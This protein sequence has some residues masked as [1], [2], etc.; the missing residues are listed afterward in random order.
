MTDKTRKSFQEY[1]VTVVRQDEAHAQAHSH[2]F[3]LPLGVRRGDPSAGFN[4]AETLLAALGACLITN[5]TSLAAKMRLRV[6]GVR[7]EVEGLRQDDPPGIVQIRYRLIL[8]SPEPPE[9]LERLHQLAVEW[10]TV[11][12]TLLE[13]VPV[14]GTMEVETVS[15][16]PGTSAGSEA[17]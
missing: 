8:E 2:G 3:T 9:R 16:A 12:N 6:E 14:E 10:G 4:A 13:G 1:H 15:V 17:G 7:V 11:T 5:L